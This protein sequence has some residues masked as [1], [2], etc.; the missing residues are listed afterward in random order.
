MRRR[1]RSAIQ[2]L[3]VMALLAGL[4]LTN[5]PECRALDP[6]IPAYCKD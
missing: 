4:Y 5:P 1:H 2:Y 6:V 3:V